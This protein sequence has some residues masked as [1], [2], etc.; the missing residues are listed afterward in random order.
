MRY[1]MAKV[2]QKLVKSPSPAPA[3]AA[4]SASSSSG[5]GA[6]AFSPAWVVPSSALEFIRNI[7]AGSFSSVFE[8]NYHG[9]RIAAKQMSFRVEADRQGVERY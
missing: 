4:A 2:V 5:S 6:A 7:G 1:N 3:A 9:V 8:V